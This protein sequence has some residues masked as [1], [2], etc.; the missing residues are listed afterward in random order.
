MNKLNDFF[1]GDTVPLHFTFRQENGT[2]INLTGA[3]IRMTLK[4]DP[5][6]S[7]FALQKDA[8][9]SNQSTNTGEALLT[10]TPTNTEITPGRYYYD[11]EY[12]TAAGNITTIIKSIITVKTDITRD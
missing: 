12:K 6:A 4:A 7:E 11:V 8:V 9:I 1:R 3:R 2:L 10:L 5:L